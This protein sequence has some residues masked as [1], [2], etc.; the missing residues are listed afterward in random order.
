MQDLN[1]EVRDMINGLF[2]ESYRVLNN[3]D[4]ELAVKL[5]E[6]AWYKF[7]EPKFDW[8]VSKSFTHALA[9]TYR[10]AKMYGKALAVM[11]SLFDSG[12]VLDYQDQPRFILATIYYHQ[13]N[14]VEAKKWFGIADK[15]SKGRCFREEPQEY[16]K[17]YKSK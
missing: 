8:D 5:A 13:G 9:E 6:Q 12:T 14:F 17:F 11:Q 1:I 16:F 10:D 4:I 3:G 2:M 7:P 15:I